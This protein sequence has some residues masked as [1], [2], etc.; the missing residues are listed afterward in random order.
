[1]GDGGHQGHE[2]CATGAGPKTGRPEETLR[3][4]YTRIKICWK[5]LFSEVPE[6]SGPK[7][8]SRP[9]STGKAG[10]AHSSPA[11]CQYGLAFFKLASDDR[12]LSRR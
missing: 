10:R 11:L 6:T 3:P 8:E 7:L 9:N 1:M 2:R 5:H 12:Q 4:R